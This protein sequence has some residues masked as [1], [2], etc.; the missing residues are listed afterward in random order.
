M[1][2]SWWFF[3]QEANGQGVLSSKS[4]NEAKAQPGVHG[5]DASHLIGGD[6]PVKHSDQGG[7]PGRSVSSNRH[8]APEGFQHEIEEKSSNNIFEPRY[9]IWRSLFDFKSSDV[10]RFTQKISPAIRIAVRPEE[11]QIAMTHLR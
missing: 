3:T 4:P 1:L 10:H 11:T 8:D 9:G 5:S 6:D 7:I 2:S